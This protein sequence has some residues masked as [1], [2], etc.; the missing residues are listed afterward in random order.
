MYFASEGIAED[1]GLFLGKL[2][3]K[4]FYF[5]ILLRAYLTFKLDRN[6]N[7]VGSTTLEIS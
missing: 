4:L 7:Y 1:D 2:E 6:C 5:R 3:K